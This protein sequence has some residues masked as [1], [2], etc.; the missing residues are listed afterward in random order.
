MQRSARLRLLLSCLIGALVGA[1]TTVWGSLILAIIAGWIGIAGGYSALTWHAIRSMP[2]PEVRRHATADEPGRRVLHLALILTSVFSLVG[3]GVL[4]IAGSGRGGPV[5]VEALVGAAAVAASW[6]LVHVIFTL[7]YAALYY[8]DASSKPVDFSADD[9]DYQDFAYL[10]FTLGMTYQVSDTT[11]QTKAMRRTVLRHALLSYLLG[12]VVIASTIN[13][14]V[15][16][17]SGAGNG[18][19]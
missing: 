6:V 19:G 4:L 7:R 3:V 12:A 17:A 9:P 13:L 1:A 14:V 18:A 16:L 8:Q 10:A 15:Q 2:A 5:P 11:L